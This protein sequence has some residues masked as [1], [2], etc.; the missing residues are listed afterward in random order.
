MRRL[1]GIALL[2]MAILGSN[3]AA[4]AAQELRTPVPPAT[5][6]PVAPATTQGGTGAASDARVDKGEAESWAGLGWPAMIGSLA[7]GGLWAYRRFRSRLPKTGINLLPSKGQDRPRTDSPI[8]ES[9]R[10]PRGL[11]S[12]VLLLALMA[13]MSFGLSALYDYPSQLTGLQP[14]IGAL[15]WVWYLC[16]TFGV[17]LL[18]DS[19]GVG[20]IPI[21]GHFM[22]LL[23]WYSTP[24]ESIDALTYDLGLLG[25]LL[26]PVVVISVVMYLPYRLGRA[27]RRTAFG[28]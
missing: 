11:P 13:S 4:A 10:G 14:W 5:V 25:F 24:G 22:G 8:E 17:G 6:E 9:S 2:L 7:L 18:S 12:G 15:P 19:R 26:G 27:L 21:L 1:V 3:A 20:A 23:V 16:G 28:L